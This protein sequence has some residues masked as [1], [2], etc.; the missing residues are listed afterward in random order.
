MDIQCGWCYGNSKNIETVYKTFKDRVDFEFINGG[1]WVGDQAPKGGEQI[2]NYIKSQAP[3]LTAHTGMPL[4]ESFFDLIK[5]P[6]Y[7][8]SSLEPSA[9]VVLLKSLAPENVVEF[10]KAIQ[11]VHFTFGKPLDHLETYL[12]LLKDLPV[13]E[14]AFKTGWLSEENLQNTFAEFKRGRALAKGFPTFLYQEGEDTRV[15]ASGYFDLDS[16]LEIIKT[17]I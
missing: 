15:L 12:P 9:A 17:L 13:N 5:D 6:A 8:L 7:T 1:M 2:S 11:H 14:E 4:S 16:M 10:A 3:R